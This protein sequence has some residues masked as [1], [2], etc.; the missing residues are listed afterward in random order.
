M[1]SVRHL[2]QILL[3]GA[4]GC[5]SLPAVAI[6]P[7]G[8]KHTI[9][10]A[11][12]GPGRP[13]GYENAQANV[14]YQ[15]TDCPGAITL[16]FRILPGAV[17][18]S[19]RYWHDGTQLAAVEPA[20]VVERVQFVAKVMYRGSRIATLHFTNN[21]HVSRG[22]AL[23]CGGLTVGRFPDFLPQGY[24]EADK[25]QMFRE[26]VIWTDPAPQPLTNPAIG[27][28][29][30]RE[31]QA[32]E[33]Q[34]LA[35]ERAACEEAARQQQAE[36]EQAQRQPPAQQ[37]TQPP[38]GQP[39][40]L[41]GQAQL[42]DPST[43]PATTTM[44]E[45]RGGQR[46]GA[47]APTEAQRQAAQT[48]AQ[49]ERQRH[50]ERRR[51]ERQLEAG[52][53]NIANHLALESATRDTG[54]QL[55]SLTRLSD[56]IESIEELEAEFERRSYEI[57]AAMDRYAAQQRATSAN[58]HR[59]FDN[60]AVGLATQGFVAAMQQYN[61]NNAR[62]EAQ[63]ELQRERSRLLEQ[64]EQRRHQ[65]LVGG[66]QAL[67]DEF[68][69]AALPRYADRVDGGVAYYFA[70][71]LNPAEIGQ[72]YRHPSVYL[73]NVFPVAQRGDGG[74]PLRQ[75]LDA[76]LGKVMPQGRAVTLAGYFLTEQEA[77]QMR[78]AFVRLATQTQLVLQPLSFES[79]LGK[80]SGAVAN[81]W[82][83]GAQPAPSSS[84]RAA[85]DFWGE[86]SAPAA[87][88]GKATPPAGQT[89]DFWEE[90]SSQPKPRAP[91]SETDFWR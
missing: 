70:Y 7:A 79:R 11:S 46:R 84:K 45:A 6:E 49:M 61:T 28:R 76:E 63:E 36:Q 89:V 88:P 91:A 40:H 20:P 78:D 90:G 18:A 83:D 4:L 81:F 82:S 47:P 75:R 23:G 17:W 15:F 14:Q 38:A 51:A 54:R 62:N 9:V 55:A 68:Q 31:R 25:I 69:D 58:L 85:A 12:S 10:Y 52:A 39:P 66:R 64:L 35:A 48:L 26:L 30:Q 29:L 42:R 5:S 16:G 32:A 50:I 60:Q 3:V 57:D 56:S 21:H 22:S 19:E 41:A 24:S 27:A 33:S 77:T 65:A 59:Q 53:H 8:G 67:L 72:T 74:W 71:S 1:I 87:Q 44:P 86:G 80:G 13:D 2:C 37:P 34:R 73:T 43:S